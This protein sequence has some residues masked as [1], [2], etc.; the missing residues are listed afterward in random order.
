MDRVD[1]PRYAAC[2]VTPDPGWSADEPSGAS[3]VPR[4]QQRVYSRF[5]FKQFV[6]LCDFLFIKLN[7]QPCQ[8]FETAIFILLAS[9]PDT[10]ARPLSLH[11]RHGI[12]RSDRLDPS[13]IT[14]HIWHESEIATDDATTD[15]DL[16][17]IGLQVNGLLSRCSVDIPQPT[18]L[19]ECPRMS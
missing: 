15:D 12:K 4:M 8:D 19:T 16:E 14:I 17:C 7:I 13:K 9:F 10:V 2:H 3:A 1:S 11:S 5:D 18:V 6:N